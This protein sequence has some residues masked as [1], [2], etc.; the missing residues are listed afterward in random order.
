MDSPVK[1]PLLLKQTK[2]PV[3]QSVLHVEKENEYEVNLRNCCFIMAK[4][5][6]YRNECLIK[7]SCSVGQVFIL[8]GENKSR[9]FYPLGMKPLYAEI[10][11]WR[12]ILSRLC[13]FLRSVDYLILEML[14][15]LVLTAV[16]Q[17]LDH[18]VASYNVTDEDEER[19]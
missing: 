12:K 16:R 2:K 19:V 10:S 4:C 7:R 13:S 5:W 6:L 17:L 18:L 11:E 8:L 15:R 14:R 1:P 9:K 3:S